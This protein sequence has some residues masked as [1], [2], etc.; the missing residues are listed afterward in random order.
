[1]RA[2]Q[3]HPVHVAR[4]MIERH[5]DEGCPHDRRTAGLGLHHPARTLVRPRIK[6]TRR[7]EEQ[8]CKPRAPGQG[9]DDAGKPE[10]TGGRKAHRFRHLC[11]RC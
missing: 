2:G 6:R 4:V 11:G 3:H 5:L 7:A 10:R 1:M 8:A 9:R